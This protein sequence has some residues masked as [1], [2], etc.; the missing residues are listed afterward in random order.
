MHVVSIGGGPAGLTF[1][2]LMKRAFPAVLIDVFERNPPDDASGW[3][4]VFSKET[5][6][7]LCD[8]D[9]EM[10]S[11]VVSRFTSWDDIETHVGEATTRS[12]GHGFCGLSRRDLLLVLQERCESL[13]VE[14]HFNH[15]CLPTPLPEADLVLGCDGVDSA[16]R[17]AYRDDFRP[18]LDWRKCK[19]IWLGTN[20]PLSAFTFHFCETPHGL[21][22]IH[23]YPFSSTPMAP[24]GALST[25]IVECREEVW[26]AAGLDAM[27]EAES[28]AYL[29]R[30]FAR[31]LS[32][33]RLCA[34]H[35]P[36]R[37]FPTVTC[38]TWVR[39]PLVLLGDAAHTAHFSVGS[40]TKLAMEDAIALVAAFREVGL[41]VRRALGLYEERRKPEVERIQRAAQTSLEW[42]ENANR[43]LGQ[44]PEQFTF[45]LMT[46][47]RRITWANLRKRDEKLVREADLAFAQRHG[48]PLKADGTAP[49][50]LFAPLA[51]RGVRLDN[52][53]VVSPMCQYS[54]TDGVPNDWHLVHLGARAVG[55][56]ALV[57]AEMTNVLAE[58]R[59]SSGCTGLWNEAQATAWKRIVD[60]VHERT[61]AKVGLQLAHAGRRASC[62][63]PWEG[64][65]PLGEHEGPWSTIG[66]SAIPFAPGWHTPREMTV[67]DLAEVKKAFV[68]ATRRAD[69][70]GFDVVELHM[71]HGYL[72]S[73]FLSPLCNRRTD[74]Y[75][76]SPEK[77]RRF[78]LEV[79]E[80]VRAAWPA[81]KP[82]FVRVSAT[83]W[84][85]GGQTVEETVALAVELKALGCDVV[86][87]STG[88]NVAESKPQY[89]RMYQVP[90]AEAVKHGAGITVM[91]VGGIMG[92]DHV[93]T[94]IGAGRADL[95]ALAKEHLSDPS[96]VHRHAREEGVILSHWP[97]QYAAV[98]PVARPAKPPTTV[99]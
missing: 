29:E 4:V 99:R 35:S 30:L 55:G 22:R 92:A 72:L 59:I 20:Q 78:P 9:P 81:D 36:W 69:Q 3:G 34:S 2:A 13:G 61:P 50:P 39:G 38:A 27:N 94:I 25:F 31:Q 32:G 77:R 97:R 86:D 48:T 95:C 98:A 42:F 8:A 14:L 19:F 24:S 88:G 40:G 18:S 66:P 33:H 83:D 53:V 58:G 23:A 15:E 37:T 90:F 46:R 71:A 89:G 96:L 10:F 80:A 91:A 45:N 16:V 44:P 68:A 82:L 7:N 17:E 74:A 47:S 57:L 93:N 70:C 28:V 79:F 56:A 5:L 60:F 26:R 1:A 6:A 76:G 12:T 75:G 54:A 52:R 63:V 41:D 85:P 64:D 51:L 65:G 62:Q 84:L 73:S 49:P 21:F 11:A 67:N 43:Y 87:V